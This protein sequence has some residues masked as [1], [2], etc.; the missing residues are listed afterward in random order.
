MRRLSKSISAA[1]RVHESYVRRHS[2]ST[3]IGRIGKIEPAEPTENSYY[4][5]SENYLLG[6]ETTIAT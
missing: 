6:Y 3:F 5:L 1:A 2:N 4:G